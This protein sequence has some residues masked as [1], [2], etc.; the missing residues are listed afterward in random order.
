METID[1]FSIISKITR[2]SRIF[3]ILGVI[4]AII[5]YL[6]LF[7][8]GNKLNNEIYNMKVESTIIDSI[9]IKTFEPTKMGKSSLKISYARP[10]DLEF[11]ITEDG[12]FTISLQTRAENL[13]FALYNINGTSLMPANTDIVAGKYQNNAVGVKRGVFADYNK[14]NRCT[15]SPSNKFEGSFTFL[16]DAGTYYIRFIRS[17]IGLSE[18]NLST[19]F[20]ELE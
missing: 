14:V 7:Y 20:N 8:K 11:V 12:K 16:L 13:F 18:V 9:V 19:Q 10:T 1:K 4:C 15:W 5:G 17:E 6:L 2:I 3:S